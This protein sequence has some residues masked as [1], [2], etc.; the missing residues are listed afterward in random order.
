MARYPSVDATRS[1]LSW[2]VS[3]PQAPGMNIDLT[4]PVIDRFIASLLTLTPSAWD[5]ID[6]RMSAILDALPPAPPPKVGLAAWR[7]VPVVAPVIFAVAWADPTPAAVRV[8]YDRVGDLSSRALLR[9]LG[10][11]WRRQGTGR[12]RH[13]VEVLARGYITSQVRAW[14]V[15]LLATMGHRGRGTNG[16][17]LRDLYAPFDPEIPWV[18]LLPPLLAPSTVVFEAGPPSA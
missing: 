4:D 18:S 13:L 2:G 3:L 12:I 5:A 17:E 15:Y 10:P 1:R 11:A 6:A 16:A 8:F 9:Y 7:L 14:V